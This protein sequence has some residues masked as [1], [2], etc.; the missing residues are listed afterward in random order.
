MKRHI[1]CCGDIDNKGGTL[2]GAGIEIQVPENA[3][4]PGECTTIA[5]YA[6]TE[7]PRYNKQ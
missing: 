5:V 6:S 4:A 1:L 7:G 3:I 2:R